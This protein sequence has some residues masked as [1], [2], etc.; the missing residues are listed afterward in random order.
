MPYVLPIHLPRVLALLT[1]LLSSSTLPSQK[2]PPLPL[3][4]LTSPTRPQPPPK[5][6][7]KPK[8]KPASPPNLPVPRCTI[9]QFRAPLVHPF[10]TIKRL[11]SVGLS[12][13]RRTCVAAT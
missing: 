5:P 12:D 3:H 2:S 4:P 13:V 7:A 1:P 6:K 11:K 9:P 8:P 10:R